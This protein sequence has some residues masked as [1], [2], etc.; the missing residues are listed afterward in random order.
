MTNNGLCT[1]KKTSTQQKSE[2]KKLLSEPGMETG[3]FGTAV[4]CVTSRPARQLSIQIVIK[5]FDCFNVMGQF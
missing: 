4:W 3:T 5:L 2:H 1:H